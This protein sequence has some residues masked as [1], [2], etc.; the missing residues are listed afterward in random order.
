MNFSRLNPTPRWLQ[1]VLA[2]AVAGAPLLAQAQT[3]GDHWDGRRVYSSDRRAV[4]GGAFLAGVLTEVLLDS[5]HRGTVV[6]TTPAYPPYRYVP[7]GP[8]GYN[9]YAPVIVSP[10]P[11]R[12]R[13]P[14]VVVPVDPYGRPAE[15]SGYGD[16]GRY[17]DPDGDD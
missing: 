14:V 6:Y 13:G 16:Y 5:H 4:A 3:R 9:P 1:I 10:P 7:Y 17:G 12:Y 2:L 8:Y 15:N 11:G